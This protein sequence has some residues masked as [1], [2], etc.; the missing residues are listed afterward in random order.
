MRYI[1]GIGALSIENSSEL[2]VALRACE[3]SP[4]DVLPNG[5]RGVHSAGKGA[6]FRVAGETRAAG[7]AE[8]ELSRDGERRGEPRCI[9]CHLRL[10]V[11]FRERVAGGER[12]G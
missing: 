1:Q 7:V 3:R 11:R 10:T 4:G 5:I 12:R 8:C 6:D 9:E 2:H